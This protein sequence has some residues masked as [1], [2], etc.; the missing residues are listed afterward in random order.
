MPWLLAALLG[1]SSGSADG[2]SESAPTFVPAMT[3]PVPLTP[4]DWTYPDE[5]RANNPRGSIILKCIID[6]QGVIEDC[7]VLRSLPGL[8][9]PEVEGGAI[10]PGD[11]RRQARA[12]LVRVQHL[13][14]A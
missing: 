14:A 2:G 8:G 5:A 4:I 7:E 3:R 1:F 6:V 12:R 9:D 11:G 13:A 10:P